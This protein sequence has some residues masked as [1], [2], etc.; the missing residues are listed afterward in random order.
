[1]FSIVISDEMHS[2]IY[3][4]RDRFGIKPLYFHKNN[5]NKEITFCSEIH[6][7]FK[8]PNIL[9]KQNSKEIFKNL[10]YGIYN[11]TNETWFKD[12]NQVK[13]DILLK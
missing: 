4:I 7:I 13:P 8:N 2:K 3:L 6:P 11:S 5:I 12:I 10:K 9:K 1:M